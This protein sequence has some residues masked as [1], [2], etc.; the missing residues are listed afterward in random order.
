MSQRIFDMDNEQDIVDLFNLLPDYAR[1]II[2]KGK[3]DLGL[4]YRSPRDF[5]DGC[6]DGI[7]VNWH[8]KTRIIRPVDKSKW[9]GCLVWAC[10]EDE[11]HKS[12]AILVELRKDEHWPCKVH[13]G[14]GETARYKNCCPVKREEIKFVED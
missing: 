11:K 9:I 7:L 13:F 14:D 2:K 5:D 1:E 4:V 10:D 8:G 6:M 12:L 3:G